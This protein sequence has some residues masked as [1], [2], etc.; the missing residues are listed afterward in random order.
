MSFAK[1]VTARNQSHGFFVIHGHSPKCL[2]DVFGSQK[3]IRI[4]IG[5]FRVHI[6]ESHLNCGQRILQIPVF[7]PLV[8]QPFLFGPPID[9]VGF[10]L[11]LTPASVTKVLKPIDSRAT[12]PARTIRSA[13]E[14]LLPYFCL[15]GQSRRRALSRFALSGQLLSGSNRLL[16]AACTAATVRNTVG[17]RTVPGHPNEKRCVGAVIRR[18]PIL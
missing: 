9:Q 2:P 16:T 13:Q 8:S 18:P 11:I 6:N 10:P 7:V 4:S 5:T 14:M 3:R 15:T 17:S 12:L 1:R